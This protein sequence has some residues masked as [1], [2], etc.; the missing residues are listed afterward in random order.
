MILYFKAEDKF[1][2]APISLILLPVIDKSSFIK[3]RGDL[4]QNGMIRVYDHLLVAMLRYGCSA[5]K[6]ILKQLDLCID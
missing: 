3:H 1:S 6:N 4:L 2:I 5:T